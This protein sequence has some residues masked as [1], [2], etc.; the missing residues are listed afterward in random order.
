MSDPTQRLALALL[1]ASA[2]V[3]FFVDL[4]GASIW[5]ANEAFYVETPREM[6]ERGDYVFPTFNYEPRVNKPVLSYWIVAGFYNVLGVSVAAERLA[7]AIGGVG[8]IAVAFVLGWASMARREL[9]MTTALWAALGLAVAPRVVMFSRRIFIDIWISCFAALTLMFFALAERYPE[10]RRTWLVLMYVAAGL[11][12]LTKGPIAIAMP[13]LAFGAY[14]LVYREFRRLREMMLPLGAVIVLAIVVP[15]YAALY[16]RSGWTDI[17]NFIFGENLTRFTQGVGAPQNRPIW[18]YI[19]VVFSDS[20]P[21]SLLLIPAI[22]AMVRMRAD[23]ADRAARVRMV[24]LL[25]M[26]AFVGFFSFSAEKQDLYIFPIVPAIAALGAWAVVSVVRGLT[27]TAAVLGGLLGVAGGMF[28]FLFRSASAVYALDGV[29]PIAVTA[30][31]TGLIALGLVVRRR[32]QASLLTALAGS[33]VLNWIFVLVLIPSF[34]KYKPSPELSAMLLER[35]SLEDTII[36]YKVD[37]PSM[38][39]YMRRH[40]DIIYDLDLFLR[41]MRAEE[42]IFALLWEDQYRTLAPQLP[43]TC[44]VHR[45]PLFNIKARAI[46][47]REPLPHIV[48]I[49]NRCAAS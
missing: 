38:V 14:L 31:A 20:F 2:V 43:P 25:W 44:L 17:A 47:K 18:F 30:I 24:L 35:S 33:L 32:V 10:R 19:P 42:R 12:V 37:M 6:V 4:G 45:T 39:F 40:V 7:I 46:L 9:A 23:G 1:L 28:L 21:W 13:V 36:Q 49:T 29:T 3:L 27:V 34:E 8:L 16:A 22:A 26:A 11:G 5:D 15:W 41:S 48:L